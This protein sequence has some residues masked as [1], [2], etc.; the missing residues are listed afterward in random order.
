MIDPDYRRA[1]IAEEAYLRSER[2][3]FASGHEVQ[4]WL[5]AESEIDT[6]LTL[7]AVPRKK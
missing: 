1:L 2:R 7:G 3:G 5:A 4:D 6:R